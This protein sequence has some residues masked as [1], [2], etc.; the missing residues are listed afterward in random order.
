ME[1]VIGVSGPGM[2]VRSGS[3]GSVLSVRP[4]EPERDSILLDPAAEPERGSIVPAAVRGRSLVLWCPDW[5][6]VAG[7]RQLGRS[8]SEPAAVLSANRVLTCNHA[9]RAE[10]IRV[11]QRRREAQSRFPDLLLLAA[12]PDR[13]ARMFEPIAAAVETVAPGVEILRPGLVACSTRGPARFFGSE[14]AAAERIVD[15]VEALDVECRVGIADALDV[16]VLAARQSR[17]VPA[18]RAAE[19]CAALPIVEL[20]RDPAIAPPERAAL[21][22]LLTRLGLTTAGAFAALPESAVVTR[23]GADGLVAHRLARGLG[24]RGLSRRVIGTDLAVEQVCDPPLERVDTAAFLARALAE[25]FH[26][27]LADAGMACTRVAITAHTDRDAILTRVWR[28]ARPLT[29]AATADRLRW[30]L[31][32]W[33]TAGRSLPRDAAGTPVDPDGRGPGAITRLR[34]EPVEAVGAGLIQYG[35]WG[36]DG[37]SDQRAGWAFARI[38][39]LLGPASVLAPVR[40]GGRGPA[41][42]ITLVPWGEEKVPARD[43]AAPWPGA[44]PSPS[45]A[46]LLPAEPVRLLDDAGQPVRIDDRGRLTGSPSTLLRE[47]EPPAPV[48]SW[49]GPWLLDERWWA[50]DPPPPE[51]P[52]PVVVAAG[53]TGSDRAA[54]GR[55]G[56]PVYRPIPGDLDYQKPARS[57][58][59]QALSDRPPVPNWLRRTRVS[60]PAVQLGRIQLLTAAAGMLLRFG[61]NGWEL[62]GVY[63]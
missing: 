21:V 38:Q 9:A 11:G 6:A 41:D 58:L 16:A 12:D 10:G 39:G 45:P 31:D 27:R 8:G 18:G 35:L 53:R 22:D 13:D 59:E 49:A 1:A 30:Q 28:C 40:S 42:R 24:D 25:R 4:A 60:A 20:A 54:A 14:P 7:C 36:S 55:A 63:D 62:E 43:P 47:D 32:G 2:S 50:A 15:L 44:L 23:F 17:L 51:P 52:E 48:L 26:L 57:E 33:L 3:G 56:R 19:F 37:E 5:P 34:L 46:S 61:I 29:A